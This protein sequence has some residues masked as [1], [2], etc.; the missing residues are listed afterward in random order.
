MGHSAGNVN[1]K[2]IRR[3]PVVSE[4]CVFYYGGSR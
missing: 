4:I 1:G 3:F 2:T